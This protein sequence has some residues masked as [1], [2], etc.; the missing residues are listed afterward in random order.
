MLGKI[1]EN[2]LPT[3]ALLFDGIFILGIEGGA[4]GINAIVDEAIVGKVGP[5]QGR[6]QAD[7]CVGLLT[8]RGMKL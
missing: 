4:V 1:V 2:G 6:R 5:R 8:D 7:G 3:A